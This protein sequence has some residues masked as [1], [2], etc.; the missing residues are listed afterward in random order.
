MA[1]A[2]KKAARRTSKTR[3]SWRGHLSFGLVSFP[4]EAFNALDR[5]HSD[6]HFHQLHATCHSR[7]HYQKVCPIHGEVSNDEIISGYEYRKGKYIEVEPEELESLRSESE[8]ALKIDAFVQPGTVDPLYFDGRMYYLVPAGQPAQEP[9]AVIVAAMEREDRHGIGQVVFSGKDQLVLVRPVDGVL[10]M[11]MLNY[12]AEIRPAKKVAGDLKKPR[13]IARQVRLAQKL[14]EEWS[15]DDFDFSKY[16]DP[17]REKVEEL[18]EA[19]VK[20]HE[21]APAPEEE[22]AAVVSLMDAL[23]QS[24]ATLPESRRGRGKAK[25]HRRRSA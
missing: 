3:A 9:Y 6:I 11:A 23:K 2:K 22:P 17:Y 20:G 14:I 12:D 18:I 4:V 24:V 16:Q 5:S 10:H 21:I 15:E 19:K 8:R 7:I 13:D 1:R 25:A